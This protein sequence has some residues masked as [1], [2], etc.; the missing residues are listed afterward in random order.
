MYEMLQI[1]TVLYFSV[2]DDRLYLQGG[3]DKEGAAVCA[4]GS[5]VFNPGMHSPK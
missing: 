2:V 5:Y 1:Y 4:E 3:T